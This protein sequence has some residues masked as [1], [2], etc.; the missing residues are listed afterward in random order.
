MTV[1]PLND[2]QVRY[3]KPNTKPELTTRSFL[4]D[5]TR[6]PP[7]RQPAGGT[8]SIALTFRA[9]AATAGFYAMIGKAQR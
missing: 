2:S 8:G 5:T 6:M 7:Q 1:K 3:S 4:Y 9:T